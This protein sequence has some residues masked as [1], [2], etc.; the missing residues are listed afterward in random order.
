MALIAPY[1]SLVFYKVRHSH[2]Q[3]RFDAL[4]GFYARGA[5]AVV[6]CYD[7]TDRDT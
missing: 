7:M 2:G 5:R 1:N 3:E 6:I 4:T